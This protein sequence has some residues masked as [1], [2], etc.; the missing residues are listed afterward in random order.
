MNNSANTKPL[1]G[2]LKII[3]VLHESLPDS[4]LPRSIEVTDDALKIQFYQK[5]VTIQNYLFSY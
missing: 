4:V 5:N 2:K 1:K 3:L